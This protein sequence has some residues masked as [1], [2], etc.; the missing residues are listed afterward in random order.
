LCSRVQLGTVPDVRW[1]L[2]WVVWL[3]V[4]A[5]AGGQ[6][7]ARSS[8]D[9][10]EE[11]SAGAAEAPPPMVPAAPPAPYDPSSSDLQEY[12][13]D[14]DES[15]AGGDEA[16]GGFADSSP[17]SRRISEP[18]VAQ[19]APGE[20]FATQ[21]S[22][23]D[24]RTPGGERPEAPAAQAPGRV[25]VALPAPPVGEKPSSEVT[26]QLPKQLLLIYR[27]QL[28][29][30]V[31]ETRVT[32]DKI[33]L[34]A[35]QLGGYLVQRSNDLIE[36]RVPVAKFEQALKDS[37]ALGDELSRQVTAEDVSDQYRDLKIRLR[38]AE[39]VRERLAALLARATDVKEALL[40]EEQL[41]RVTTTI[42]QLKG[43]LKVLDELI[44][45]STITVRLQ[46]QTSHEKLNQRVALPFPWL[47][48][49][50]L[51]NLLYLEER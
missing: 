6:Y 15:W 44:A 45:F 43:K 32:L 40:V 10:T 38:N 24:P 46:P 7:E 28:V 41:G 2:T 27:A 5:C 22:A 21:M 50:G 17:K 12:S 25:D 39:A 37:A 36:V 42:E 13:A 26:Q 49:L 18:V 29:L 31:F 20:V 9:K 48:D 11:Y 34:L 14:S 1:L 16:E 47:R 30:A 23:S 19:R 4:S 51:S 8:Y 3:G 33:E 35:R